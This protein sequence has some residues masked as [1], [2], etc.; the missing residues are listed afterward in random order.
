MRFQ[1]DALDYDCLSLNLTAWGWYTLR[2]QWLA[3]RRAADWADFL[4]E[5]RVC[6]RYTWRCCWREQ[7]PVQIL[8]QW[9][10]DNLCDCLTVRF[11]REWSNFYDF[12]SSD[13]GC[14]SVTLDR[15]MGVR[16]LIFGNAQYR[17]L[18]EVVLRAVLGCLLLDWWCFEP[19]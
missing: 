9:W 14:F 16:A 2:E 15:C 19:E 12:D 18:E 4:L 3:E 7:D 10:A 13:W 8:S 5:V 17:Y 11:P 1:G 6:S